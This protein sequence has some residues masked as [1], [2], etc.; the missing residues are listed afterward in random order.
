MCGID[1]IEVEREDRPAWDAAVASF[2]RSLRG[3]LQLI[4]SGVAEIDG[5]PPGVYD[6]DPAVRAD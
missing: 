3:R 4:R 5:S 6:V 1:G 2:Q